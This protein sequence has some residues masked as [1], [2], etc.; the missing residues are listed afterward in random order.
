M[1]KLEKTLYE[2]DLLQSSLQPGFSCQ[3]S[4]AFAGI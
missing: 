4:E 1:L 3:V 2:N